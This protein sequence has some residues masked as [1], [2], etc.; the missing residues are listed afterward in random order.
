MNDHRHAEA[1]LTAI[2]PEAQTVTFSSQGR[3]VS[4][5]SKLVG[6]FKVGQIGHLRERGDDLRTPFT[7]WTYPD[8]RLRRW[9]EEDIPKGN[10]LHGSWCWRLEGEDRK[11]YVREGIIPGEG[12]RFVPDE[13]EA[14]ELDVPPEFIELCQSKGLTAEAVLRGF[15]AD[16]CRLQNFVVNPR[17]DGYSSNGS[18]ERQK[19]EDWFDRALRHAAGLLSA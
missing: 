1:V 7:F 16:V 9:P 15:I 6:Y 8:Q 2:D 14:V 12:G 11:I 5:P 10:A 4:Y 17:E 19:A 13:T 18:D 3:E